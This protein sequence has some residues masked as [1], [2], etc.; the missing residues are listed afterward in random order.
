MPKYDLKCVLEKFAPKLGYRQ[1]DNTALDISRSLSAGNL[2]ES[3]SQY[4]NFLK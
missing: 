3:D 1:Y 2:G 4:D